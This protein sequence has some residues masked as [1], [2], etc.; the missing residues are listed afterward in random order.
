MKNRLLVPMTALALALAIAPAISSEAKQA[1]SGQPTQ[2]K[3]KGKKDLGFDEIDFQKVKAGTV[4]ATVNDK[5]ITVEEVFQVMQNLPQQMRQIPPELLFMATR[6]QLVDMYLLKE[7]ADKEKKRIE[8][9]PDVVQ[10]IEKAIEGIIL[11]AYMEEIVEAKMNEKKIRDRYIELKEKF[12]KDTDEIKIR[13]ILVKTEAEAKNIVTQ[14]KGG[15]D[16]LKIAREK[17][18]DDLTA[19]KDGLVDKYFN[20]LA[21]DEWLP[22]F[23]VLFKKGDKD[24]AYVVKT[25]SVISEP[26][27]TPMGYAIYKIDDRRP[28]T[29]PKIKDLKPLLA[30]QIKKEILDEHTKALGS[31]AKI[32]RPHPNTGKMM[33]PLSE[34]LKTL[35]DKLGKLAEEQKAKDQASDKAKVEAASSAPKH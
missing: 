15:D 24:K 23:E 18:I 27:K 14:L 28:F 11:Q 2:G 31:N 22:G 12:P 17:S 7:K 21:K 20:I 26:V 13:L 19:K 34:E 9:Y 32:T 3:E 16:F 6:D 4:V 10:S 8:K 5:K 1:P 25:G 35:Q 29:F 30:E 33:K